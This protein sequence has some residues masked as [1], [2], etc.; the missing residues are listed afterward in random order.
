MW[1]D[2][3]YC[4]C[5]DWARDHKDIAHWSAPANIY[6]KELPLKGDPH[7][8]QEFSVWHPILGDTTVIQERAVLM[9]GCL[10]LVATFLLSP[11]CLLSVKALAI[12]IS[13]GLWTVFVP[14]RYFTRTLTKGLFKDTSWHV[15][16]VYRR[17]SQTPHNPWAL[18][19]RFQPLFQLGFWLFEPG[20]THFWGSE[21]VHNDCV[22][23]HSEHEPLSLAVPAVSGAPL[24]GAPGKN[25]RNSIGSAISVFRSQGRWRSHKKSRRRSA[26]LSLGRAIGRIAF[27][28]AI[29]VRHWW[30]GIAERAIP[31]YNNSCQQTYA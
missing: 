11:W 13:A 28:F 6:V 31:A 18:C 23:P 7:T 16:C 1:P 15:H 14:D 10:Y 25:S 17:P 22:K 29:L 9:F 8:S 24:V 12:R 2:H 19:S 27:C 4:R 30:G 20:L 21:H 5:F 3:I 26:T